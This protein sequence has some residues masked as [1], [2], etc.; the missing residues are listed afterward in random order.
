M[1]DYL[2]WRGDLLFREAP[3]NEVDNLIFSELVYVDFGNIVPGVDSN[4][5]ITLKEASEEF[6]K[7]HTEEEI[8][9]KVS[10]TKMAA[11]L[12]REMAK[13]KRFGDVRLFRYIDDID[14]KEQSQF[15][16]VTLLLDDNSIFVSYSGTDNT[17]VGWRE[18]FN[19]SFLD[20]TPGQ[21]KAVK[22][23]NETI[24]SDW[25]ILRIGGHSKGGNLAVYAAV[26]CRESMQEKI[27]AVYCNDGPGFMGRKI[28]EWN[29]QKM[30]PK[31]HAFMPEASI[32]GM[33]LEH[34]ADCTVVKSSASGPM[35]HD[36]MTWEVLGNS[37]V[38]VESV[39]EKSILLDQTL[40]AWIDKMDA[41]Q[42]EEFVDTL[43][44]ILEE[45]RIETVDDLA[46]MKWKKFV[47]LFKLSSA[48]EH[49]NQEILKRTLKLLLE[50]SQKTIKNAVIKKRK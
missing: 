28:D 10:S 49:E 7:H 15:C 18:N 43:F 44:E 1:M 17:I 26:T 47:E 2:L 39:A 48:L 31:I 36:T 6:F 9:S 45:G 41:K 33:L 23:L 16:A 27:A 3:F 50:E 46:N 35:Q 30:L 14:Y 21:L 22:Y 25:E 38:R 20:E 11:F 42:R 29:Y 24:S 5:S 40:K 8:E 13:T 12:M 37:L 4:A 32:V 19:M 34:K